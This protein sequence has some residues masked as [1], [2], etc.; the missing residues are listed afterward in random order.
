[1]TNKARGEISAK[2]GGKE[3]TFVATLGSIAEIETKLDRDFTEIAQSMGDGFRI[4][5][6]LII[7]QSF[8][9]GAGMSEEDV[10]A[11]ENCLAD[12][13]LV[14]EVVGKCVSAAFDTGEPEK[15]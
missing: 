10:N 15:N 6:L 1:M 3:Y 5:T 9:K 14:A 2:F 8:A 12:V 7:I 4:G 13:T 11:L